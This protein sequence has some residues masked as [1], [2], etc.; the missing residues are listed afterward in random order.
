MSGSIFTAKPLQVLPINP[1]LVSRPQPTRPAHSTAVASRRR[2]PL[3]EPW[4]RSAKPLADHSTADRPRTQEGRSP[5]RYQERRRPCE[6]ALPSGLPCQMTRDS[7]PIHSSFDFTHT[8]APWSPLSVRLTS[9][10]PQGYWFIPT[11]VGV[12]FGGRGEGSRGVG[13]W[14]A[15]RWSRCGLHNAIRAASRGR[16]GLWGSTAGGW[17]MV[18]LP[19]TRR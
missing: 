9:I 2:H 13:D 7:S 11:V 5:H 4:T 10:H 6:L 8:S 14:G 19:R 3:R 17:T 1:S 12:E 15:C 16:I 18:R